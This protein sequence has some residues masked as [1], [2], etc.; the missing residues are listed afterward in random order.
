[1]DEEGQSGDERSF[2]EKYP[3]KPRPKGPNPW[4]GKARCTAKECKEYVRAMGVSCR[5]IC[6]Q[7]TGNTTVKG[8]PFMTFER[9][10]APYIFRTFVPDTL[11]PWVNRNIVDI[12]SANKLICS[13]KCVEEGL[14]ENITYRKFY[15]CWKRDKN[16]SRLCYPEWFEKRPKRKERF[17]PNKG[18][19]PF[20]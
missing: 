8:T 1:M 11:K 3:R 13:C 18:S 4:E 12:E 5:D 9:R 2:E 16:I 20:I 14:A 7:M 10:A 19:E 15:S 17:D 6:Q